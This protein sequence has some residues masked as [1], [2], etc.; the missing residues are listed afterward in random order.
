[1][2]LRI[3]NP[4]YV[5][6]MWC[7]FV[8]LLFIALGSSLNRAVAV[9][10][11]SLLFDPIRP[12]LPS[13]AKADLDRFDEAF[14]KNRLFTLLHIIAGSTF[15]LAAPLQ[16]SSSIRNRYLKVHRW[17][18]RVTIL[19]A[20]CAVLS[21]L[22]LVIPFRFTGIAATSG[23]TVFS[24]LFLTS[25]IIAFAAIRHKDVQRHREWMIRAFSIAIG[26][27]L[28]RIV[29][30]IMI[31]VTRV[32]TFEQLGLAFWIGWLVSVAAGELY[33]NRTRTQVNVV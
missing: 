3:Q 7:G 11:G 9:T 13:S 27:S 28:I 20:L 10:T 31:L 29:G 16:F 33:L 1:M 8:F 17:L 32:P 21:A 22:C 4:A 23:I 12:T 15:L 25:L 2:T 5:S 30:G 14:V 26:I 19:I 6:L 18:G 24:I